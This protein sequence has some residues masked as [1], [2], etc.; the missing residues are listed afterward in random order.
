MS[1]WRL[2][3]REIRYRKL[4]FGLAVLSVLTAV[5]CLVAVLTLLRL[6]DLR[7]EELAAAREAEARTQGVKLQDDYR[8]MMLKLGFNIQI[9]P[10]DQ[11]LADLYAADYA[12]RTMPEEYA[13]RLA[14]AGVVTVNHIL[15]SLRQRVTW[16]E[17]KR[18][19]LI[20][21]V[22]GELPS[23]KNTPKKPLLEPVPPGTVLVGHE[24]HAS[25]GLK[26]GQ[27]VRL[28][29]REFTVRKLLP[30]TGTPDDI[31]L[32]LNLAEAQK[33]L[34]KEGRINEI[35]ALECNCASPDRL[36]DVRKEVARI[37][38]DTQVIE[39]ASQALAR[40]EAR[41]RAAAE[42][43]ESARREQKARAELRTQREEF[44]AVLVPLVLLGCTVWVG[45]LAFTNV[46]DRAGEIGILRA[47]GLGSLRVFGL[48]LARAVLVGLL[49]ALL[50]YAAGLLVGV[51]W[52]EGPASGVFEPLQLAL[53]VAAA[54]VLCGLASWVPALLA[55]RQDPAVVLREG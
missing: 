25:L 47:L 54:P 14:H 11:N 30:A 2:V 17:Q 7:T 53:V 38:P 45:L 33:L 3:L 5:G 8:K 26:K 13:E 28:L 42:A 21:G 27:T 44:A 4:N 12:A 10:K 23:G 55:S 41:N 51:L 1:V 22:R 52:G 36:G 15:P 35:L 31:T 50:G 18:T 37:L 19:I 43:R 40:A 16:E 39:K 34:N 9:L 29:G 6:D 48:F 24:L 32:W 20:V 46:S 49:G